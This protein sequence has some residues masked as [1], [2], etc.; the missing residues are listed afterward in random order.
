M[1]AAAQRAVRSDTLPTRHRTT[2]CAGLATRQWP[3]RPGRQLPRRDRHRTRPRSRE[4]TRSRNAKEP[5][6][7]AARVVSG[8]RAGSGHARRRR[9][10]A[11][12]GTRP[13]L[14]TQH[15]ARPWHILLHVAG[16][17]TAGSTHLFF[18]RRHP[19]GGR[20]TRRP[21][22]DVASPP[23]LL[24]PATLFDDT[25]A[26][27]GA[28]ECSGGLSVR[29][30]HGRRHAAQAR[31][32]RK[33]HHCRGRSCAGEKKT[34]ARR[35]PIEPRGAARR[36]ASPSARMPMPRRQASAWTPQC[37]ALRKCLLGGART[38]ATSF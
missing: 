32:A 12:S 8:G 27:H 23:S 34:A 2:R 16:P 22:R 13:L 11:G 15:R 17:P 20:Q 1:V 19:N 7:A 10:G 36:G 9:D 6:G 38:R 4:R 37:A 3:Q 24:G 33:R 29:Q 5:E 14:S 25:P 31:C 30:Q 35:R 18:R 26:H 28:H 21:A